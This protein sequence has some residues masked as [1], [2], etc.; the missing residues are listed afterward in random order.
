MKQIGLKL[1]KTIFNLG[2][3]VSYISEGK[4][5]KIKKL[6][7]DCIF[8]SADNKDSSILIPVKL[9]LDLLNE[10]A[11]APEKIDIAS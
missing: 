10:N 4:T 11:D 6:E 8:Y 9:A 3:P 2:I 5:Y 1:T 7:K